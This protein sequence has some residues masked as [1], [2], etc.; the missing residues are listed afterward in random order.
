MDL[1]AS[2]SVFEARLCHLIFISLESNA[3]ILHK[4]W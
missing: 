2:T 1:G 4:F 3:V